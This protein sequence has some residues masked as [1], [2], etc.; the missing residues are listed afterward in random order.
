S[1]PGTRRRA[2][3]RAPSPPPPASTMSR[4]TAGGAA[5]PRSGGSSATCSRRPP[6]TAATSTS[7]ASSSTA[8]PATDP[9]LPP[10]CQQEFTPEG[11]PVLPDPAPVGALAQVAGE[12]L[13]ANLLA[14]RQVRGD[15]ARCLLE[16]GKGLVRAHER[17]DLA[18]ALLLEA[19]ADVDEHDAG[20]ELGPGRAQCDGGD[21]T[22][23]RAHHHGAIEAKLLEQWWERRRQRVTRHVE[24]RQRVGVAVGGHVGREN[25]VP[26]AQERAELLVH[27]G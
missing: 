4:S 18:D 10:F 15:L 21:A 24:V 13:G 12:A 25:M 8:P 17:H 3:D 9:Q 1:A 2:S 14:V 7:S 11:E 5:S 23:G 6:A 26:A 16:A 22:E 19:M 20:D 27:V